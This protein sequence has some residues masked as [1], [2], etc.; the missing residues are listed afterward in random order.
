[1]NYL[2]KKNEFEADSYAKKTS[3]G[4]HLSLA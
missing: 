3:S 4:H 2:S 1:M